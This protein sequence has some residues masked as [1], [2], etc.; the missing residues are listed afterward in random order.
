MKKS[1]L[2][3]LVLITGGFWGLSFISMDYLVERLDPMQVLA[4]RWMLAAL[5][6]IVLIALRV[7]KID[8]KKKSTKYLIL[9]AILQPCI[10][11][12][13]EIYGIKYTSVSV[14]SILIA[15]APC[16]ALVI[17]MIFYHRRP[18]KIGILG[19]ITAFAGV[20]VANVFAPDASAAGSLKGYLILIAAI[21]I[22]GFYGYVTAKA[23]D[24]FSAMARTAV[25]SVFGAL[26][27]NIICLVRG[28]G[29]GTYTAIFADPKIMLGIA[30]LGI[31]CS[32]VCYSTYNALMYY[33]EPAIAGNLIACI[34][35]TA[36]VVT[37]HLMAGDSFGW[38]T[39]VGLIL[40]LAGVVFSSK[41]I[42]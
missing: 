37:G 25:M 34:T 33:M 11:S 35:T 42:D 24:D 39:V 8:L 1:Y 14:S 2:I 12:I 40:T 20:V 9:A 28:F 29:A 27:F 16:M 30:F 10:Y 32:V 7:I 41:S 19:I 18:A 15:V 4:G 26:A 36:G 17:G 3:L 22:L 21:T 38:Y 31:I 6:F 13:F 23:G 5:V